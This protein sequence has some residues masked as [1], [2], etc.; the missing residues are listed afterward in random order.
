MSNFLHRDGTR[1]LLGD[2]AVPA[3]SA[4]AVFSKDK[5]K[6]YT[7]AVKPVGT[8][9]DS[10]SLLQETDPGELYVASA[11][12]AA[13]EVRI[14]TDAA[15]AFY[16]VGVAPTVAEALLG[17]TQNDPGALNATGALTAALIGGGIVTSTTAA[18]VVATLPTGTVTD[19]ALALAV[20]GCIDWSAINTGSNAFTV[21]AATAHTIVGAGAV[22]AGT[23]GRFRTRKTA[24]N[25]YVTYR[26]G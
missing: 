14:E 10:W 21:T 3:S 24:A 17:I 7:R 18:A 20:N 12:S 1:E 4:V 15:D 16:S 2:D 26:I 19:A 8:L 9:A 6:I 23:S 22:A 25:T 5:V 11:F 13:K